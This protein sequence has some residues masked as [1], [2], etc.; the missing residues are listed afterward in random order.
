[1]LETC[2]MHNKYDN[3]SEEVYDGHGI[4]L[5][6]VCSKCRKEKL[7][8]YRPDIFENYHSDEPLDED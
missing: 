2:R 5:C 7:S 1:M 6:R 4:Y 8:K 3:D